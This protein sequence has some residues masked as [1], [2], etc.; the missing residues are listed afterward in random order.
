MYT[1]SRAH[2]HKHM[3]SQRIVWS[4]KKKKKFEWQRKVNATTKYGVTFQALPSTTNEYCIDRMAAVVP[5][6][7]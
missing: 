4:E 5:E 1:K 7:A 2:T 3:H 6:I